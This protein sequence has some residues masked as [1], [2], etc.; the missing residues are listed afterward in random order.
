MTDPKELTSLIARLEAKIEQQSQTIDQYIMDLARQ[1]NTT[2][3]KITPEF[4]EAA[5]ARLTKEMEELDQQLT[6]KMAALEEATAEAEQ[7]L[8]EC[9]TS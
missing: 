9:M 3:D 5:I 7:V 4:V 6:E 2:V 1:L 8:R